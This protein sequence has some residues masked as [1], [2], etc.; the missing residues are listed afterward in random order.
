MFTFFVGVGEF[1]YRY[2]SLR[3]SDPIPGPGDPRR[4][5]SGGGAASQEGLKRLQ[6]GCYFLQSRFFEATAPLHY[7]L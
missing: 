3:L 5:I 1:F 6:T 7:K 4:S 2:L